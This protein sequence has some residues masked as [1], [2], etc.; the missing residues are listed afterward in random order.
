VPSL[1]RAQAWWRWRALTR[2]GAPM[3]SSWQHQAITAR[4]WGFIKSALTILRISE[5]TRRPYFDDRAVACIAC[6]GGP[7]TLRPTIAALRSM[8][9]PPRVWPT[10]SRPRSTPPPRRRR[11]IRNPARRLCRLRKCNGTITRE[12]ATCSANVTTIY[13]ADRDSALT[14]IYGFISS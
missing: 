2:C 8:I 14:K 4:F 12:P 11:S 5:T 3:E 13:G 7:Q 10:P 6:A 1:A 9:H